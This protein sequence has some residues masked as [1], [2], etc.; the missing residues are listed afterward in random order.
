MDCDHWVVNQT[1]LGARLILGFKNRRRAQIS[2]EVMTA[3]SVTRAKSASGLKNN[4]SKYVGIFV[5]FPC[6]AIAAKKSGR[7]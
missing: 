4:L 5:L 6:S 3:N 1:C 7:L 2:S